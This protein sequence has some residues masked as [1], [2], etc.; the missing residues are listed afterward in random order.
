[1]A[2]KATFKTILSKQDR[3]K[4]R[5]AG[6]P[7]GVTLHS[8]TGKTVVADIVMV[9]PDMAEN[10]LVDNTV[11]YRRLDEKRA[12][13]LGVVMERGDWEFNGASIKFGSDGRLRDGQ[14]RLLACTLSGTPFET[15]V[16]WGIDEDVELDRG[17]RRNLADE[18]RRMGVV[19]PTATATLLQH[20]WRL[21]HNSPTVK[22]VQDNK[23]MLRFYAHHDSEFIHGA[24]LQ[25]DRARSVSGGGRAVLGATWAYLHS[26]GNTELVDEFWEA[27]CTGVGI[28]EVDDPISKLRQWFMRQRA[29]SKNQRTQD[30]AYPA[31][32]TIKAWNKWVSGESCTLLRWAR[33]GR[34]AEP[35]PTPMK[36]GS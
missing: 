7:S 21:K 25:G 5:D 15:L 20:L 32:L 3:M 9:T 16:L 29:L 17:K 31:A 6:P 2:K 11:N 8:A 23:V 12:V 22:T 27:F 14:H 4:G 35:F 36:G 34:G 30:K 10:W 19:N 28:V 1:M 13:R 33:Y 26:V 24:V 18:L